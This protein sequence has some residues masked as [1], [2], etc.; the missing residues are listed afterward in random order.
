VETAAGLR[1]RRYYLT[2]CLMTQLVNRITISVSM[3]KVQVKQ[4]RDASAWS[5]I[6]I[7][8]RTYNTASKT[9]A[10]R[11]PHDLEPLSPRPALKIWERGCFSVSSVL[12]GQTPMHT[13]RKDTGNRKSEL[14]EGG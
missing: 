2:P 14:D 3:A 6:L 13:E 4:F 9:K 5:K 12:Y 10:S 7:P 8:M 1:Q 11:H